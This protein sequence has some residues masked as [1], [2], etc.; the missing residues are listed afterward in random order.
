MNKD[1]IS[2]LEYALSKEL[3]GNRAHQEMISYSRP[4]ADIVKTLNVKPRESAVLILL[5]Q[6]N[7]QVAEAYK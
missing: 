5:Y 3:P 7:A 1:L 2:R 4:S 6:D